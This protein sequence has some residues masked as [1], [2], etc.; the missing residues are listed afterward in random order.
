MDKYRKKPGQR[1]SQTVFDSVIESAARILPALGHARA[2]TNRIAE[3]AGVS[4]GSLYQYFP[5]KDAIIA[6]L[7]E[8][9]LEKHF[10]EASSIIEGADSLPLNETIDLLVERFY[11]LYIGQKELSRELFIQASKLDQVNEML[12][13]RNRVIDVLSQL[14]VKKNGISPEQA[15]VK[16]F[17]GLNAF[18]GI[19]QTCSSLKE[20]PAS[21]EEIK[22]QISNL[23]KAY[24]I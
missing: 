19:I 11:V 14:L 3:R 20:A 18:M 22:K 1:R 17:I 2:T 4:I 13:V 10:E 23:L 9:E 21:E 24:L 8:R 5:N 16:T 12:F 6:S 15:K 7:I